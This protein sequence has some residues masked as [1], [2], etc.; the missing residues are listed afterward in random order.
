MTGGRVKRIKSLIA[1]D[2]FMLTYGEGLSDVNINDLVNYHKKQK[3]ILTLTAVNPDG[4]FGLLGIKDNL[5]KTFHEKPKTDDGWINGGFMV[6]STKIF[7]YLDSDITI[8][9]RDPMITLANEGQIS[10]FKH[11]GF[12]QPMDTL[13]D[14]ITLESLFNEKRYIWKN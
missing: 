7:N 3:K 6:A 5:V 2:E 11:T 12:W 13:R 14:K 10:A 8:L 4:R 1:E 9:E